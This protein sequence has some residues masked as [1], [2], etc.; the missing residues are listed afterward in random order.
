[1]S[2]IATAAREYVSRPAD[3]RFPSL[4]AMITAAD[5]RRRL[6][7]ERTYNLKD[8]E[9]RPDI[10]GTGGLELLSPR[11]AAVFSHWSFG[12]LA[13]TIGAPASYLRSLPA[14]IASDAINYGLQDAGV[15]ASTSLLVQAPNG[16]PRP[17]VRAITTETYARVWESDLYGEIRQR[18]GHDDRW[19]LPPTWSGEPAGAY[20]GDRDSFLV[21]VNGGSIVT[22]PTLR[23]AGSGVGG[24]GAPDGLYR[25]LLVRNSEVGA[26]S[27]V[28]EVV[29]YRY[30]CGNHI[31]WGASID[32]TFRRRH[33]GGK[34][35]RDT[36]REI[37]TI[38]RQYSER[39]A[40]QDEAIIRRLIDLEIASTRAAVVDELRAMGATRG[41]AESAYD[42][43]ERTERA[44]PRSYWGLANGLTRDS[45]ASAYQDERYQ[46]DRLAGLVLAR[47]AK[48][49]AA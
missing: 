36:V 28:V 47:G 14:S 48:L 22:D 29:L 27:V 5:H 38:A 25:G 19:Q 24:S 40:S 8:L 44:A 7:V 20:M 15:G 31:L 9:V 34:V 4:D 10:S 39:G 18:F 33:V 3:E 16:A 42:T 2:N 30:I 6:S 26:S 17:L 32:R 35:V 12:Q 13:R 45:Q 23:G 11:G 41:Q 43:A 1:M 37:M 46:L 49:V 21:W